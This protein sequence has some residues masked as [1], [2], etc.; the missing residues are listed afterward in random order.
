MSY[1]EKYLK[2]KAKYI[3]LK[4]SLKKS[5]YVQT[6]LQ[7][8]GSN[9]SEI[10]NLTDTP[11]FNSESF[12]K[13]NINLQLGGKLHNKLFNIDNLSDTP[14]ISNILGITSHN[15]SQSGGNSSKIQ[16]NIGPFKSINNLTDTPSLNDIWGGNYKVNQL[17]S[18]L[19]ESSSYNHNGGM[20]PNTV[21]NSDDELD[22]DDDEYSC[23]IGEGEDEDEGEDEGK[24][25]IADKQTGGG[26]KK[27]QTKSKSYKKFFYD[28][29]DIFSSSETSSSD[30]SSF[31]TSS[32]NSSDNDL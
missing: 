20:D 16:N 12:N 4:S 19:S 5:N 21:T 14:T 2:Y 7:G 17:T 8:G 23:D 18:L 31:Y 29:S 13:N 1:Q 11:I 24:S 26:L 27:G 15:N 32:L 30:L 3:A 6:E 22:D 28:E 25:N 9:I 10:N